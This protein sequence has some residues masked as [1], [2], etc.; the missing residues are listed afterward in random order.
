MNQ[1]TMVYLNCLIN[2]PHIKETNL[3]CI[4]TF[5]KCLENAKNKKT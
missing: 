3:L 1:C 4:E 2:N 5:K